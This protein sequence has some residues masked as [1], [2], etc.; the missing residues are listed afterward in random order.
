MRLF[1]PLLNLLVTVTVAQTPA[2]Y[3]D[4]KSGIT[5]NTLQHSSGFFFGLALPMNNTGN[6]DFIATIGGK[7]TGWSGVSLAGSMVNKLLIVAWPNGQ[8]IVRSFRKTATY[9]SP[10]VPTG[11]FKQAAI[12]NGTYINSTHWTYTFLCSNC[13][14]T[15]GTTFKSSD[16][17]PSIG[18]AL[19][20]NAPTDKT[21]P[22]SNLAKHSAR[23]QTIFDLSKAR[24]PNFGTWKGYADLKAGISF[25]G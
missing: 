18:Y 13:L 8:N 19:N 25:M 23:D 15:D 2:P 24:S 6:S 7:G 14:Q 20:A 17:T 5:F 22:A 11:T 1:V 21:N 9:S 12:A 10:T 16:T 4:T 3:T